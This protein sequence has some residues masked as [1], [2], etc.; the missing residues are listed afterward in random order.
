MLGTK[1]IQGRSSSPLD[2]VRVGCMEI[3][4]FGAVVM[5]F[6]GWNCCLSGRV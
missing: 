3:H 4:S 2:N 1:K 6:P 5:S